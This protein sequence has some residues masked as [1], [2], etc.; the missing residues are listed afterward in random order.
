MTTRQRQ[1]LAALADSG[2]TMGP[3]DIGRAADGRDPASV[4]GILKALR[5]L[6]RDGLVTRRLGAH[7]QHDEYRITAAGREALR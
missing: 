4:S 1:L 3:Y 7:P 5:P 2:E 6:I